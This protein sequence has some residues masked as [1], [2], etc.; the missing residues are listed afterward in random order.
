MNEKLLKVNVTEPAD[1][2]KQKVQDS[3]KSLKEKLRDSLATT[4]S[5]AEAVEV[6]KNA[7]AEQE[8]EEVVEAAVEVLSETIELLQ[9]AVEAKEGEGGDKKNDDDPWND[10][11]DS[12]R[13]KDARLQRLKDARARRDALRVRDARRRQ[14][15]RL[16]DSR[17]A[18][19]EHRKRVLDARIA[20]LQAERDLYR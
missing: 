4:E 18:R 12:R 5:T 8:P 1:D 19:D 16:R 3:V 2:K 6:V 9:E 11:N 17:L 15:M 13:L 20:R 7:L 10:I 14:A